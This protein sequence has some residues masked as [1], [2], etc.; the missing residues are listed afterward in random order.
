LSTGL[1]SLAQEGDEDVAQK[2][3]RGPLIE[4]NTSSHIRLEK[5]TWRTDKRTK[6]TAQTALPLTIGVDGE[7]SYG[8]GAKGCIDEVMIFNEALS[9]NSIRQLYEAGGKKQ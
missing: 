7:I 1:L 8:I 5:C 9:P 2:E 3:E 6:G 4:M